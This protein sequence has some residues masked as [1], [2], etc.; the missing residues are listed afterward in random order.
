MSEAKTFKAIALYRDLNNLDVHRYMYS[1]SDMGDALTWA[2]NVFRQGYFVIRRNMHN[3][4]V[5]VA[6]VLSIE[7]Y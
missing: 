1:S 3:E 6:R 7:V 5:P 4:F 2:K